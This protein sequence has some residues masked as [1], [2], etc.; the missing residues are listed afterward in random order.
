MNRK[1]IILDKDSHEKTFIALDVVNASE[2]LPYIMKDDVFSEFKIISTILKENLRNKDKYCNCSE[3]AKNMYEMRFTNKG[4]ND[5]I[6]CQEYF[7]SKKRYI[8]MIELLI[9]KKSQEIPKTIKGR[10][11]TMGGYLY[12]IN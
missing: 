2:I 9:G 8:I 11:V 5:R 3:K 1:G 7:E 4:R 12:E 10:I 6:Y